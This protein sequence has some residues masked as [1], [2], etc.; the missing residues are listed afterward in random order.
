MD[1]NN[2]T[3]IKTVQKTRTKIPRKDIEELQKIRKRLRQGY[4]TTIELHDK[5]I[6]IIVSSPEIL[7]W[8]N[9]VEKIKTLK[10]YITEKYK[11]G[12]SK[13]INHMAQEVRENVENGSKIWEL[14][15]KLKKKVQA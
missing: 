7:L 9:N 5:I 2:R 6:I 8:L 11:E 1:D 13:T 10:E 12:R 14:K 3:S 15:R 4:S